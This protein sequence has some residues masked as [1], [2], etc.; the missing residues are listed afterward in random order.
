M[1]GRGKLGIQRSEAGWAANAY[2]GGHHPLG[3]WLTV[4][5]QPLAQFEA[6]HQFA[7]DALANA[8]RATVD[9]YGDPDIVATAFRPGCILVDDNASQ[10]RVDQCFRAVALF[11]GV[12]EEFGDNPAALVGNI[13]AG[14]GDAVKGAVIPRDLGVENPVLLYDF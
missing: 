2:L 4:N 12:M 7:H 10:C 6:H 8:A 5:M 13:D 1:F 11:V 9:R 3:H 14:K